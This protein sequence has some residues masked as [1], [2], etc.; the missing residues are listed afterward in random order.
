LRNRRAKERINPDKEIYDAPG[1]SRANIS[2]LNRTRF[3]AFILLALLIIITYNSLGGSRTSNYWDSEGAVEYKDNP[4]STDFPGQDSQGIPGGFNASEFENLPKFIPPADWIGSNWG[5]D[6]SG[7]PGGNPGGIDD[8]D[9][10]TDNDFKIGEGLDDFKVD[11]PPDVFNDRDIDP[12]PKLPDD[13]TPPTIKPVDNPEPKVGNYSLPERN[14]KGRNLPAINFLNFSNMNIDLPSLGGI[15]LDA[16]IE[17]ASF[18][19]IL[20]AL[21]YLINSLVPQIL[22]KLDL[23]VIGDP[24]SSMDLFIQPSRSEELRKQRERTKRLLVFKDHVDELIKRSESRLQEKGAMGTIITGYHELDDAFGEFAKL[25]RTKDRTPLEH[26]VQHFETGE[27]NNPS[28][29]GIVNLF[30]LTRYGHRAL[31]FN[32]GVLFISLLSQLVLSDLQHPP[33]DQV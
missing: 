9:D 11:P 17:N 26:A 3:I 27:I 14:V 24:E 12:N 7:S 33:S 8:L 2:K 6:F 28:L 31:E 13:W 1:F 5:S 20:L 19:V 21:M 10:I 29:K 22:Q 4:Q 16:N 30:Y 18:V 15:S 25:K 32:D 23:V